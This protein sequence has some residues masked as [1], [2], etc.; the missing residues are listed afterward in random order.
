[1][2]L[3][4]H[5]LS[6]KNTSSPMSSILWFFGPSQYIINVLK[7]KK[8]IH[9]IKKKTCVLSNYCAGAGLRGLSVKRSSLKQ[10]GLLGI[11]LTAFCRRWFV[12][13]LHRRPRTS[14]GTC[15]TVRS[16]PSGSRTWTRC[17][18][19]TRNSASA[20]AKSS[21][22]PRYVSLR[23]TFYCIHNQVLSSRL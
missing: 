16:T 3:L 5:L 2:T 1:M 20:V 12:S 7:I 23:L 18:T 11:G 14:A 8:N 15:S 13:E 9:K 21:N 17:S 19:T 4:V 10:T 6:N 22:S